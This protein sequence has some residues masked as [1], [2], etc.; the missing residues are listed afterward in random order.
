MW[1]KLLF[2]SLAVISV[3]ALTLVASAYVLPQF[4]KESKTVASPVSQKTITDKLIVVTDNMYYA[5]KD[6]E[7][8]VLATT[9]GDDGKKYIQMHTLSSFKTEEDILKSD[10]KGIDIGI[11]HRITQTL[12]DR[13]PK[14]FEGIIET[15]TGTIDYYIK[16]YNDQ[17][18][19][20]CISQNNIDIVK[21]IG[22]KKAT[23]AIIQKINNSVQAKL[24]NYQNSKQIS[25]V[26][27]KI[28]VY[29]GIADVLKKNFAGSI[30]I[31]SAG[32]LLIA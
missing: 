3:I 4:E 11:I 30:P 12:L 25:A 20:F 31:S 21:F 19:S 9:R 23:W 5:E 7:T 13:K 28:N 29:S 26:V 1:K 27:T 14:R 17:V 24:L 32:K 8:Y 16:E 22:E 15:Q 18:C 2:Y 10:Q 6:I